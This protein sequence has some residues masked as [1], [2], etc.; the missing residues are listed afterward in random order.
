LDFYDARDASGERLWYAV[1]KNFGRGANS[2][3]NSDRAGTITISDRSGAILYDGTIN[4][5]HQYGIAAIIIA[6]GAPIAR[7]GVVQNRS[8]PDPDER[9]DIAADTEPEIIDPVNYLDLFGAW[10]NAEFINSDLNGFVTGPIRDVI[11]GDLLV[12]DQMIVVTAAEVVA[13]AEKAT[14]Q[15][16]REAID[17]YLA[18]TGGVYPWLYSYDGIEYDHDTQPVNVAIKKLSEFF[19]AETDFIT[20]KNDYLGSEPLGQYGRIPSIFAR[21]FSDVDSRPI[22]SKLRINISNAELAGNIT[23]NRTFPSVAIGTFTFVDTIW[24]GTPTPGGYASIDIDQETDE[25][26]TNLHFEE[27][28]S[29]TDNIVKLIGTIAA[30]ETHSLPTTLWFW[31]L[32]TGPTEWALCEGT[33]IQGC[34]VDAAFI[35]NPGGPGLGAIQILK[36]EVDLF[37]DS[38]AAEEVEFEVDVS[39]LAGAPVNPV[40]VAADA[41]GHAWIGATFDAAEVVSNKVIQIR[42]EY[43]DN[44][45]DGNW[46]IDE[47][48]TLDFASIAGANLQLGLRYYPELPNWAYANGWH[49]GIRMAYAPEYEPGA[50]GPCIIDDTCLQ[51][52]DAPGAPHDKIS[53]LVIAGQGDWIDTDLNDRLKNDLSTVFDNGNENN[54]KSFYQH[55]GNDK[56]LVIQQL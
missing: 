34:H 13:M 6:P 1:S 14:L 56:I 48:G 16:Y 15:A 43:D 18:N 42:F 31:S 21:Y 3:V 37:F 27:G 11:T 38:S 52:A 32:K 49:N 35:P 19:P 45:T 47:S 5:L 8:V 25:P 39:N 30:D 20:E 10:D 24:N 55:R 28:A 9:F 2:I 7:G 33:G 50:T 44:Y 23:Y 29:A 41:N 51:L 4:N 54:N 17:D 12:N 22:E 26:V 53:L 36:V 46:D 40:I